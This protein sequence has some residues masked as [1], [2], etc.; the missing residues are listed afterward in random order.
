MKPRED[1]AFRGLIHQTTDEEIFDRLDAGGISAYIGFDPTGSSLHLGHLLQL[2]NL[3]RLQLAGNTPIALAGGG[4]A[5]AGDPTFKDEERPLLT[6]E[7]IEENLVG[8]KDKWAESLIFSVGGQ[9]PGELLNNADWLTTIG[10]TDFLRVV[11]KHFTVNQMVA[12]ESV[13]SRLD[14]EDVGLSFIEFSYMLLQAYDFLRLNLD[15]G[16]TLHL[17]GSDQWGNITMGTELI[18]KVTGKSATGLTSPLLL[19]ADGR[20]FGKSEGGEQI[21][22]DATLTSPFA[23]HQ[24]L[25]NYEDATTPVLLRFFTFLDHETI[26]DLDEALR[27]APRERVAQRALANEV[28]ALVHGE[29]AARNAER[30]GEALFSESIGE[31]DEATLL[32]AVADAPS[33]TWSREELAAGVDPVDLLVRC[34]LATSKADARRNLDQGGVYVNNVRV[35]PGALVD[36]TGAL[37]GRYLVVRRGAPTVAPRGRCVIRRVAVLAVA[38]LVLC[39]CGSISGSKAMVSWVTQSGYLSTAKSLTKD[40]AHSANALRT[41]SDSKFDLHTVCGVLLVDTE[42][43]NASLPTPDN[44]ATKLLSNAYTDLGAGANK[45]YRANT[46]ANARAGALATLTKGLSYLSE[47]SAR[48]ASATTP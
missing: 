13:K 15:E 4:T 19:R 27:R 40:A 34:Q 5:L 46:S 28:V 22:L 35:D 37:H 39:A 17:G 16:C 11:G 41:P 18:R 20:K 25:L 42:S 10:L 30:A 12:K 44:V 14:R 2:C 43:A 26:L 47:A 31:L 33:S 21:W 45:C 48:I 9:D 7:Q 1:W 23:L 36:L 29:H 3:R 6:P 24:Y 32:E 8:I 38:G